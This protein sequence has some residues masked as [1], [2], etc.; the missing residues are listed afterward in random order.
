MKL[1]FIG[2]SWLGSCA[3]SLKE[4]LCRIAPDR[5]CSVDEINEDL[6]S[7]KATA[8]WLRGVNRLLAPA[9][10]AELAAAVIEKCRAGNP[11]VV[12]IY[13]GFHVSPDLIR[14]IR[15]LGI[16]TANVF[17]DYSP[18]AYGSRLRNAIGEYD[19]VVS[20]KPFHPPLWSSVY[21]Y[22]NK[23]VFVPHGY[24]PQLHLVDSPSANEIYDVVLAA[25]C[26]P[27][28]LRLMSGVAKLL[29]DPNISVCLAGPGWGAFRNIFPAHWQYAGAPHG[30]AYVDFLRRGRISIAPLNREV[31]ID[32][33][34]QPGDEDTSRTY[35]LPAAYCFFI[36][37][38]TKYVSG[39]YS[40]TNE[41]PMFDSPE[42]LVL[43]VR[44]YLQKEDVRRKMAAAAH[45][46]AVPAYS[47]D[48]RAGLLLTEIQG[49]MPR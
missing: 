39:I 12:I 22:N 32:G 13:K 17:P 23:C 29:P 40:E 49:M 16:L 14:R 46:R 31:F 43:Q 10:R 21:G 15:K 28:Y 24:D 3:R 47:L 45:G 18:H 35:E 44:K 1:L 2:E 19:L 4:A 48:S 20:T 30:R 37:Q 38:R 6:Y 7:P 9:Y 5:K 11:D 42:E 36:H 8:R 33:R 41:V 27:Q 26:R 25:N 34:Q